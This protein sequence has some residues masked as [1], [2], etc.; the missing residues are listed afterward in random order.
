MPF[1]TAFRPFLPALLLLGLVAAAPAAV[2]INFHNTPGDAV[3]QA[4]G[5]TALDNSFKFDL[6]TFGPSFVPT[7]ANIGDWA[8]NWNPF[9]RAQA[10]AF[11]DGWNSAVSYF[12]REGI[13]L[14]NGQSDQGLTS[15]VF[16][17]GERVYLWAYDSMVLDS[18]FEWALVTNNA[19]DLNAADDWLLPSPAFGLPYEFALSTA[20]TAIWGGV[21]NT[22]GGGSFT[23]PLTA[24]QL[25]THAVPEPAGAVVLGLAGLLFQVRRARAARRIA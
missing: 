22:Q 25:Q 17:T 6:G 18:N 8:A 23:A 12:D 15:Y 21:N 5:V 10:P 13:L 11:T 2:T 19:S 24:F 20:T 16:T 7:L 3:L 14:D 4:D 1:P 9:A